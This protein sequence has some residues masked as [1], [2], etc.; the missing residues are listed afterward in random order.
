MALTDNLIEYWKL[1]GDSKGVLGKN[2]SDTLVTYSASNGKLIQGAGFSGTGYIEVANN[3]AFTTTSELSISLWMNTTVIQPAK[4]LIGKPSNVILGQNG[5]DISTGSLP[6]QLS[7]VMLGLTPF[8]EIITAN[9][10]DGNWHHIVLTYGSNN[11]ICYVDNAVALNSNKTGTLSYNYNPIA[12]GSFYRDAYGAA[13]NFTG[14]LDEVGIWKR[15]LSAG[16][17]SDL[18]LEGN[19]SQYPFRDKMFLS[20]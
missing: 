6:N 2:G 7:F 5:W 4:T 18:Y 1:D 20:I 9:V 14:A 8:E 16:E 13:F 19:G 17:V 10:Y 15:K 12:I 11:L 3:P